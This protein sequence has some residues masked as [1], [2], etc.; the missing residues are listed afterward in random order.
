MMEYGVCGNMIEYGVCGSMIEYGVCGNMI[1]YGV[2]GNLVKYETIS[3]I[4]YISLQFQIRY[5]IN[6][7]IT[8]KTIHHNINNYR[9]LITANQ[10]IT[11]PET[12]Q[13][14]QCQLYYHFLANVEYF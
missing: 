8:N 2:C 9:N 7:V 11:F 5:S 14:S 6:I 3:T 4:K 1:K 10:T 13:I 12:V